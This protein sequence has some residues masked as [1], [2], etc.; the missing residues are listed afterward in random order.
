MISS[1]DLILSDPFYGNISCAWWTLKIC[2]IQG[3]DICLEK[4]MNWNKD[5]RT[6]KNLSDAWSSTYKKYAVKRLQ[7]PDRL[8]L[9]VPFGTYSYTTIFSLWSMHKPTRLTKFLWCTLLSISISVLNSWLPCA[10]PC[11][12]LLTAT[13]CPSANTPRYTYRSNHQ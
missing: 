7:V 2:P 12:A 13:T 8:S 6:D 3:R 9:R 4:R 10:N 1:T 5:C 11:W